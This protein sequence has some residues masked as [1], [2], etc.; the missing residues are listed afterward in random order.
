[1]DVDNSAT[2]AVNDNVAI[3][4]KKKKIYQIDEWRSTTKCHWHPVTI[5]QPTEILENLYWVKEWMST[6]QL[7]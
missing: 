5:R 3:K 2:L 7:H 6:T 4:R 1:M